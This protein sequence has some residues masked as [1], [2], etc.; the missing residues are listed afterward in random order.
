MI[1]GEHPLRLTPLPADD[2][3]EHTRDALASLLLPER[4]NPEGAGNVLSTLVRHPELTAAYLP[5]NAAAPTA[6]LRGHATTQ[7]ECPGTESRCP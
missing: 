6:D 7:K 4:A 3:T 2:W 1:N 5:F